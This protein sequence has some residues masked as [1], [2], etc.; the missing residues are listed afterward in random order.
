MTPARFPSAPADERV[1]L[2]CI[3][4]GVNAVV[5]DGDDIYCIHCDADYSNEKP[6]LDEPEY[7]EKLCGDNRALT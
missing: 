6:T 3:H 7:I 1:F 5:I 2:E 4:C